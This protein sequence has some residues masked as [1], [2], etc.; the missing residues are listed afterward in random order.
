MVHGRGPFFG[1]LGNSYPV[2][3][4]ECRVTAI[5]IL[6]GL[7]R[8]L[9]GSILAHECMHAYLKLANKTDLT[10]TVE[11]GICQLL[12]YLWIEQQQP[13]VNCRYSPIQMKLNRV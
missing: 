6:F 13:E 2:E 9:T 10:P 1:Q 5:L 3:H 11:E 8:L 7:P 4:R 12:A